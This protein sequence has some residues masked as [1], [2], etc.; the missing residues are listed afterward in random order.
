MHLGVWVIRA[1]KTLKHPKANESDRNA[2]SIKIEGYESQGFKIVYLDESGF[3]LDMP[4]EYG[5][6]L[7]G[8]RCYG[9]K[10][11]HAKGRVNVI[12]AIVDFKFI[13][14]CLFEAS[15]NSYIFYAWL[16][17]QL[18]PSLPKK[19]VIVMDNATFHKRQDMLD[20]IT[21][22]GAKYEF[23]PPYSPDLNPIE[24]KWA[25]AKSIRRKKRCTVDELFSCAILS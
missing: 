4:R 19:S 14:V 15:I 3:A 8:K 16:I 9:V 10:D 2:F 6:S 25:Q 13:N 18:I 11:W 7:S 21:D 1:K 22:A 20:G 5:Y 24:K 12:G 23:L 17:R